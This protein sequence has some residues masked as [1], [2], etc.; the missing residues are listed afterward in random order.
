MK[1][2]FLIGIKGKGM[3]ALAKYLSNT[4][5]KV[6]GYD[7]NIQKDDTYLELE[8]LGIKIYDELNND[9][10]DNKNLI[11]TPAVNVEDLKKQNLNI[12]K[13]KYYHEFIADLT[14]TNR[15][16]SVCGSFGKTTTTLFLAQILNEIKG[17]NYI[18]GDG[19]GYYNHNN[20]LLILES[21]EY[22]KH[23]L[24]YK[25]KDIIITNI[26]LE[27]LDCYNDL[28]DIINTFSMFSNTCSGKK[29]IYGDIDNIDYQKFKGEII[30]YGYHLC[31]DVIITKNQVVNNKTE[32]S[33]DFFGQ[34]IHFEIPIILVQHQVLDLIA[35]ITMAYLQNCSIDQII[36]VI[37]KLT[38]PKH[39]FIHKKINDVEVICDYCGHY[40]GI[41]N[42]IRQLKLIYPNSKLKVIFEPI[43]YIRM[44]KTLNLV[45]NALNK[46]DSVYVCDIVP[47]REKNT[48]KL[49]F[50]HQNILEKLPNSHYYDKTYDLYFDKNDLVAIFAP[51][52]NNIIET[53]IKMNKEA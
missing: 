37:P 52:S 33:L 26:G 28:D 53:K 2:Y 29:V 25:P 32:I 38:L 17:C 10:L 15:T 49:M 21:C 23:F 27:H 12:E 48:E 44:M 30:L 16:I 1:T 3:M 34:N 35:A 24:N 45:C 8:T 7:G 11:I 47:L 42:N 20:N 41:E 13:F 36:Q 18:V 31:N 43:S 46:A 50:S 5:V 6:E 9:I 19:S 39:R 22:Q 14:V 40:A 51:I 4:G